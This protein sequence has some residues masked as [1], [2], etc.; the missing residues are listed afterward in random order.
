MLRTRRARAAPRAIIVIT[1]R[2]KRRAAPR[3]VATL[4]HGMQDVYGSW[5]ASGAVGEAS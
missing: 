3:P 1:G 2:R 5:K 4:R